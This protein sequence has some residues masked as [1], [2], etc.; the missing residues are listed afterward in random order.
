[1]PAWATA[2]PRDVSGG[3]W[4]SE[5]DVEKSQPNHYLFELTLIKRLKTLAGVN[6]NTSLC[7]HLRNVQYGIYT[8][9]T[10]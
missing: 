9:W 8:M 5:D 4:A 7:F 6:E 10:E 1:M 3:D 2:S